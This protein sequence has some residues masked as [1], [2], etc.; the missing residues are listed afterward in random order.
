MWNAVSD[1]RKGSGGKNES[2]GRATPALVDKDGGIIETEEGIQ[3]SWVEHISSIEASSVVTAEYIV[4][5]AIAAEVRK[6]DMQIHGRLGDMPTHRCL[7][8][9]IRKSKLH[10]APGPDAIGPGIYRHHAAIDWSA[11]QLFLF[12]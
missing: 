10:S 11:S 4:D 5:T 1:F 9:A 3:I 8:Q 12:R 7:F 2:F 6:A